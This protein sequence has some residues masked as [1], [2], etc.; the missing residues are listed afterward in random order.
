MKQVLSLLLRW[1]APDSVIQFST[2]RQPRSVV[3][4]RAIERKLVASVLLGDPDPWNNQDFL[5]F[6]DGLDIKLGTK[7]FL[8]VWSTCFVCF[9]VCST[10]AVLQTLLPERKPSFCRLLLAAT[11]NRRVQ[12]VDQIAALLVFVE[13]ASY[14]D[15]LHQ[16]LAR[17]FR[18]R[19]IRWL[20]GKGFPSQLQGIYYSAEAFIKHKDNPL[21]RAILLHRAMTDVDL[22][23]LSEFQLKVVSQCRYEHAAYIYPS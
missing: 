11:S 20:Y 10:L 6:R 7:T 2:F 18:Y 21:A 23:P 1:S 17:S 3:Q 12:S 13:G 19:L 5:A 4:H 8:Q 22:V 16:L 15:E 14:F 9:T